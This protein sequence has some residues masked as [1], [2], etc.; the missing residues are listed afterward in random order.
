MR[1]FGAARHLT[2][3]PRWDSHPVPSI[4]PAVPVEE[5]PAA[6]QRIRVPSTPG[7]PSGLGCDVVETSAENG[8]RILVCLPG[9]GCVLACGRRWSWFVPTGSDIDVTWPPGTRYLVDAAVLVPHY[10]HRST[11]ANS[12]SVVHWPDRVVPYT[13]PILLYFAACSVAGV[14]PAMTVQ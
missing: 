5:D 7:F 8:M 3:V 12:H 4:L 6:R 10:G 11:A 1:P 14:Q 13:H 2:V 9:S